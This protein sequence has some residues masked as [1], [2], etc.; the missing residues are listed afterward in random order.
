MTLVE[1]LRVTRRAVALI[2][3]LLGAFLVV[4]FL[5]ARVLPPTSRMLLRAT[6][7]RV[8][9]RR[10]APDRRDGPDAVVPGSLLV[11]NHLSWIDVVALASVVPM[12]M[13][14][15]REVRSWPLVGALAA[16]CGAVFL[17]RASL[18]A[19]PATVAATADVL[20]IGGT[21]GVFPEGTT[22]CGAAAGPFRPAVF[23]AALDAGA[24]VAPVALVLR[25]PDGRPAPEAAFVGEQTLGEALL[26]GLRL[27][28]IT[29]EITVLPALAPRGDRRSMAAAA[30][31]A[32]GAVTGAPHQARITPRPAPVP[33]AA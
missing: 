33:V 21:V 22:W 31:A 15:K 16:R 20:R 1:R 2:S 23:Q 30:A 11:A 18:R 32:I 12:R 6:G 29:C 5:G 9:V 26:R 14:A 7:V 27:R 24:A 17:D 28:R 3:V 4:P 19:L 25:G 8:R 13:L 10:D